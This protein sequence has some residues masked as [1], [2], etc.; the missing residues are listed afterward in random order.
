MP[1]TWS[2]TNI[3]MY[4]D[5]LDKAWIT[6]NTEFGE[7]NDLVPLLRGLI[8]SGGMIG[9]S[10]ITYANAPDWFARLRLCENIYDVYLT[11]R[12]DEDTSDYV[13]VP[14]SAVAIFN[15]IGLNTNHSQ[16]SQTE[17]LNNIK[18]YQKEVDLTVREMSKNLSHYKADF[19]K[20]LSREIR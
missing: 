16:Y 14:I 19:V 20:E 8:F 7:Q 5:D 1:L 9:L 12:F 13:N 6:Y 2:I 11:K 17:W 4:E 15:H 10:E 18:K 3:A